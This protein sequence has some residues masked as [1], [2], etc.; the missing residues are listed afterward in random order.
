MPLA[1]RVARRLG[2]AGV[3]GASWYWR[4]ADRL[5]ATP[6]PGIVELGDGLAVALDASDWSS[7]NSYRG[8][9]ERAEIAVLR[10][11]L[12]PG[13]T[14]V[15]IGANVGYLTMVAA[16]AVGP[17]GRIV[18]VEPSPRLVGRLHELAGLAGMPALDV[19]AVAVGA[20]PG[21]AVLRGTGD[22][23]HSGLGRWPA[24][25]SSACSTG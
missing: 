25:P 10:A 1:H 14:V 15:D 23:H 20:E 12:S 9:Y 19:C 21:T 17:T 11:I 5:A 6:E 16:R 7:I 2:T 18:A 4:V 13:D 3:R 24:P 8:L 22:E